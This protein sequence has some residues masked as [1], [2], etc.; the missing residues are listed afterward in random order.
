[1]TTTEAD[2][3]VLT[4]AL[5][6]ATG[7]ALLAAQRRN[8]ALPWYTDGPVDPWD[9]VEA[10]M[11]LTV[12]GHH[13][14]AH[15]AYAYLAATQRPD[16]AWPA[17]WVRG[18]VTDAT[19]NSG[20][21]AY[22]AVGVLLDWETTGDSTLARRL[23]PVVDRA[24]AFTLALQQPDG[25]VWWARDAAGVAWPQALVTGSSSV[26]L[27]LRCASV[28]AD[29]LGRPR[30][31][32]ELAA[33]R[34]A[35]ALRRPGPRYLPTGRHA[36]DWYW[37][38]LAGAVAGDDVAQHLADGWSRFVVEGRGVRCVDDRPWVTGA[39]TAELVMALAVHGRA[40][41]GRA[42][43]G[44]VQHLRDPDGRYWTGCVL[45]EA[46]RWPVERTTWTAAAVLLADDAL[47]PASPVRRVL[48]ARSDLVSADAPHAVTR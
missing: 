42:L 19:G 12:T 3:R 14:A 20:F 27:S 39:E 15:R 43:L 18:A 11:G 21:A 8:G 13:D 2:G 10:A 6:R 47:A 29:R 45:P 34:L 32:W 30:P 28:V 1:M 25:A 31:E 22:I 41:A 37:P 46:V 40:D 35:G 16:G 24:V 33:T 48:T 23:W 4:Q 5:R 44:A 7:R 38:V 36:M 9:H 17:R 26:L